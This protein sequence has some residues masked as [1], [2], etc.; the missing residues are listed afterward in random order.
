MKNSPAGEVRDLAWAGRHGE[1][2]ERAT[3][4]LE[5][6]RA[7]D[8]L[9]V[10]LLGLRFESHIARGDLDAAG[11]DAA[12]MAEIARV[13]KKPLLTAQALDCRTVWEFRR[14]QLR[15]A[16][17][18]ARAALKAAR[19]AK[20]TYV[21]ATT[22]SRL[23]EMLARAHDPDPSAEEYAIRAAKLFD[24]LGCAYER[25]RALRSRAM[26]LNG[27]GQVEEARALNV[28]AAAIARQTGDTYGLASALNSQSMNLANLA[29]RLR[30]LNQAHAAF[31]ASGHVMGGAIA[32]NNLGILYSRLGLTS[33]AARCLRQALAVSERI[34][35]EPLMLNQKSNLA[36]VFLEDGDVQSA[37]SFVE[38]A[39]ALAARSD[40]LVERAEAH[41]LQ[42][43]LAM[44]TGEP[45][46]AVREFR[47]AVRM[48]A[49][50]GDEMLELNYLPYLVEAYLAAGREK[51]ALAAS[52]RATKLH[53]AHGF[54]ATSGS[55]TRAFIWWTHHRALAANGKAAEAQAALEMAYRMMTEAIATVSD[56]GVRRS[57]LCH[58]SAHREIIA[59]WLADA[60]RRKLPP[61]RR[62]AHLAGEASLREPF[63]RLVDTG[64]RLNELR[65]A[66]EIHEFLVEEV[67]ELTGAE[68]VLLVL[69]GDAGLAIAGSLV[70]SGDAR[71]LLR[72]VTPVLEE[73]RRTRAAT[74]AHLPA[75]ASE[76]QQRSR[77][78]APLIAENRVLGY[79]YADLDGV[80]GRFHEADRDLLGML[81]S[82]AAIALANARWSES[83]E[84]K[85]EQR[86]EELKRSN[87]ALEQRAGE[88]AVINSIQQGIASKLDFQSI[89]DLVGDKLREV[90]GTR[91]VAIDW[92]DPQ[93]NLLQ[94]VYTYEKGERLVLG[95]SVPQPAGPWSRITR[96]RKPEVCNTRAEIRAS[97]VKTIPGTQ[98]ACAMLTVP[99]LG[100][101]RV[102]GLVALEE[103]EREN[104]FGESEVR[105]LT[106]VAAS[107]GVALENA[108]LF[109]ET[110][111]RNAELA[112]INSI[113]AGIASKLDFQAIIDLVGDTLKEVFRTGDLGIRLYDRATDMVH[114]VYE[115]EHGVRLTVPP[116]PATANSLVAQELKAGRVV[117]MNDRAARERWNI[118]TIPGTDSSQ[119]AVFVPI[120]GSEG[121]IG[122]IVLENY[123]REHAFGESDVRLLT[124]VAASMGVALE[125][126]RLF[127]ETQRL[128]KAE[129][130]RVAELAVINSI[131]QGISAKLD[132]QAIVELVGDKLREVFRTGD[133][134]IRWWNE[135]ANTTAWLYAYEHGKRLSIEPSPL[136][137]GGETERA[138]KTRQPQ[139]AKADSSSIVPGTDSSLS[140]A[141]IPII[142]SD[143]A[144][145]TIQIE[146][147]ESAEAFGEAEIRLLT[148]VAGGMGI[149][150]ESA[151]N[152]AETQRLLKETEQRNAELAV[153]N[154]IQQGIAASLDFQGI[155]DLVGD[156]LREVFR[157]GDLAIRWWD[158]ATR[159]THWLYVYEHGAR[160]KL[161]PDRLGG[162][163]PSSRA[164]ATRKT[165]I[166]NAREL[167][168]DHFVPG[169]DVAKCFAI[170]PI[171]GSDRVLGMIQVESHEREDAFGDSDVRLLTTVAASMGV[172]LESARN[173]AETQRLLKETEQRNA[174]LAV[175][176]S[177]QQGMASK[178]DF[179]SI[180]DLVGNKLREVLRTGDI[181]IR[182]YDRKADLIHY[183][184]EFEHGKRLE[185]PPARPTAT[186][187]WARLV[188]TRQPIILNTRA[189]IAASGVLPGTDTA[190]SSVTIPIIA[191][192]GV[193]GNI[194]VDSFEREHAYGEGELRLLQTIAGSMG[195][196][197]E[198]ARLFDETQ[199]LLKETEQRAAELA[200]INSIQEGMSAKLDFQAIV[201]LVGDKLRVVFNT[202]DLAIRW[203]D[204]KAGLTHWLYSYE[205]GRPQ[206]I[207]PTPVPAGGPTAI[208]LATRQPQVANTADLMNLTNA[209]AGGQIPGT[210][211]SKCMAVIPIVGSDRVLGTIQLESFEKED[212]FSPSQVSLLTTVANGMGIALENA[213]LFDETQRLLKETE[214]RNAELAII[215]SVQEGL[216]S[217]LEIEAIYELVGDKIR[218]IFR[219]D[220]TYI[221]YLET[222]A[223]EIVFPY[224]IDQGATPELLRKANLRRPFGGGHTGL[225]DTI[226][227]SGVP[228]L[229]GTIEEQRAFAATLVASPGSDKD[230]NESYLGVPILRDGRPYG[231]VS[232]QSY[233]KQA[234]GEADL[235]LLGTLASSLSVALEN[236]RLFDET[237]R[238]YKESE[239][240]AAELAIIN[241]VQQALAA[242][243]SMQG[244][245]DAVGDK[246]RDIFGQRDVAIRIFDPVARKVH[247]PYIYEGGQRI[248]VESRPFL[249][250]GISAHV[251]RTRETLVIN[252]DMEGVSEKFGSFTLPGTNAEKSAVYVP[253]ISGDQVRG[254]IDLVDLERE[255]AFS[256]SDVRL[257]QTLAGSMSVAI[258]NARLFDETQRLFKE[259]EQ[260][261][262]EL[263]II[264]SVQEALAA[265]LNIQGIY[266]AVGN[267]IREIFDHRDIAIR[268][269]D[270]R[271][272]LV[273]F[274]YA[275]E[276]GERI[277]IESQ[278]MRDVGISAYLMRTRETVVVNED[279]E[280]AMKRFGSQTLP[281]TVAEKSAIY[282]PLVSG[283]QVR[284][285]IDIIDL[286]REHAFS[287]SDVRLLQ[288]LANS[289]S[290]ALE[291]ARLFDETQR[292]YK[293]SEQRAAELAVI[294]S[295]QRALAAELNIQ[296][297]YDAVGDKIREIFA[298]KDV[299]IRVIDPRTNMVHFP[300][301]YEK[302][303]RQEV[304]STPRR[305]VGFSEHVFKTKKTLVIA[306]NSPE[307]MARYG[308]YLLPG[309]QQ[310][311]SVVFVPLV[312]GDQIRGLIE[313]ADY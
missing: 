282:V 128:F 291:N 253:L 92:Y 206:S 204:Q 54:A 46:R 38:D 273:H 148:T 192:S 245:Y 295:V 196:A 308:S 16:A 67:T 214:Q 70:R 223:N 266:D 45:A 233:R 212:A 297:I 176:N 138:L 207:A 124:T 64:V 298:G 94:H 149:A 40:I 107:M 232:V 179:Q 63:E 163:G 269:F 312:S 168:P 119:S 254:M 10:E 103:Y 304:A 24:R 155:V 82:Q 145:G 154:S 56:E 276:G 293:E 142:G 229:A 127:D 165:Q 3:A 169:T 187:S 246:I 288:T 272:G 123:E 262:A 44:L 109:D 53:K 51:L 121:P 305:G 33:R 166:V 299:G 88:L 101:D 61:E 134:S 208:A 164:I 21:E 280:G 259:S 264:N 283:D 268:I 201:D 132:F 15:K 210:D 159:L 28:E 182:W 152:F 249:D 131:Q 202:G 220:T 96:T 160:L 178:L 37:R 58:V 186:G 87:T 172:A 236:A 140:A 143:R 290:V 199:R 200:V 104:I 261:A 190:L 205:H 95:P 141:I 62:T 184:F 55:A 98:E 71:R 215:N 270:Q 100:S 258:E 5:A 242:E 31:D 284:G 86:T 52:R 247:F 13:T 306:A 151:S 301:S 150:L 35:S 274:P 173:F 191:A 17:K 6:P 11:A 59:A 106:T 292:L 157:T 66:G 125:S 137:A 198:N 136:V 111:R 115:F 105:L 286:E 39:A 89:I 84:E 1:A 175:I 144:L 227:E 139:I 181:G 271:A 34:H 48:V 277:A 118:K 228:I 302:G 281:G 74:L 79:F 69:E 211:L 41:Y 2:I 117:L 30:L 68:R 156:K 32:L 300:Y 108:R 180:I 29:E 183:F 311:R 189:E 122:A 251:I 129:Q 255:H 217:K 65:S 195:V 83:L 76:L 221:A 162:E 296:G 19:E 110:Q 42:G 73:T 102:L 36:S 263:A 8:T 25:A 12:A 219:A 310:T 256:E 130:A 309:T 120:V 248:S 235:R 275:Y 250:K 257:L 209:P 240:R 75:G 161:E 203:W 213:R 72:E 43:T 216:A 4:L 303:R 307:V 177:V 113:Q 287:D 77:L 27:R 294:N 167:T 47:S 9:R 93:A 230:L 85:V 193:I 49:E 147:F 97:G 114:Y 50:T 231:V 194:V 81:A 22:L 90:L 23:A 185:I 224:Y 234:Y 252:E 313:M 99:I 112:V 26:V 197:L 91:D 279:I 239:Q 285:M 188:K 278:P 158:E 153:I 267:K 7:S 222:A 116:H 241:S 80:Y 260:R 218:E 57:F 78:V 174:E 265:E 146:S 237:Q 243:L 226:I 20:S 289:M 133:L 170:T 14:G 18:T 244:I 60:R 238:L 135:A 225:T 126:A 171:I